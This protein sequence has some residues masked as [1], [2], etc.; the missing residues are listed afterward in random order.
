MP[1]PITTR[2]ARAALQSDLAVDGFV[3]CGASLCARSELGDWVVVDLKAARGFTY[4]GI[5][6]VYVDMGAVPGPWWDWLR[7]ADPTA[8]RAHP[9]STDGYSVWWVRAHHGTWPEEPHPAVWTPADNTKEAG[10]ELGHRIG[11]YLRQ[12]QQPPFPAL[13][14]RQTLIAR[15]TPASAQMVRAALLADAGPSAELD[16][17]L[18][19]IDHSDFIRWAR[20]YEAGQR[21]T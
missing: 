13:L 5:S 15:V 4:G 3:S 17:L 1:T 6:S 10:T 12:N 2:A 11:H 18:E 14:N 9:V 7:T 8:K 16:D 20:N 19:M 21:I